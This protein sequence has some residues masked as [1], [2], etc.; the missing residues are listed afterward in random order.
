MVQQGHGGEDG[1]VAPQLDRHVGVRIERRFGRAAHVEEH[2]LPARLTRL[3]PVR[4][5]WKGPAPVRRLAGSADLVVTG[6]DDQAI[7]QWRGSNVANIVTFADRFDNV[8]QFSLLQNRRSR[9]DI[10]EVAPTG[11]LAFTTGPVYP[12]PAPGD[13]ARPAPVGRYFSVWRRQDDGSWRY[14]IDG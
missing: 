3:S 1:D 7:Y 4:I 6:D 5:V 2:A 14:V 12:L 11:D 10:V 13:T 8:T 9:P